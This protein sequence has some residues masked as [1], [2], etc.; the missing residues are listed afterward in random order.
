[1][2]IEDQITAKVLLFLLPSLILVVSIG[3]IF[4]L[5]CALAHQKLLGALFNVKVYLF[6][7]VDYSNYSN[8]FPSFSVDLRCSTV[9]SS[10]LALSLPLHGVHAVRVVQS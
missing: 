8:L 5:L 10:V 9:S 7:F 1:M 2:F 4:F 6:I 3:N